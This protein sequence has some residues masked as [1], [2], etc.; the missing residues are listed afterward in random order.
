MLYKVSVLT[1]QLISLILQ[2]SKE[3]NDFQES[4]VVVRVML[5]Q[6]DCQL[7]CRNWTRCVWV[8]E[9]HYLVC[10]QLTVRVRGVCTYVSASFS[11]SR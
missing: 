9:L 3:R 10:G 5:I 1:E 8:S 6:S 7:V 4:F 11:L 2:F